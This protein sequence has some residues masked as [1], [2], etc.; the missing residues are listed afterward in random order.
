MT[1]LT[2]HTS[3]PAPEGRCPMD[4]ACG[5]NFVSQLRSTNVAFNQHAGPL[6]IKCAFHGREYY[7]VER[8]RLAV[9][10]STYLVLNDGQHYSSHIQSEST[11]ESFC[12][13][14]RPKFAEDVLRSLTTPDDRLLDDPSASD[15]YRALTLAA[16]DLLRREPGTGAREGLDR[17]DALVSAGA[18][19]AGE[20]GATR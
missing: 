6:S 11:V 8:A 16:V 17:I 9:G 7:E 10:D 5:L 13:W 12:L 4:I 2:L 18:S 1:T 15:V 20:A 3:D 19:N 14:Y